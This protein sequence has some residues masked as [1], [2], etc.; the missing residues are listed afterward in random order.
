MWGLTD[1]KY[2]TEM[3]L[4]SPSVLVALLTLCNLSK[5]AWVGWGLITSLVTQKA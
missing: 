3:W 4:N 5:A 1:A 2:F